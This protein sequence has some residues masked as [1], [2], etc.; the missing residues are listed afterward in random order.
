MWRWVLGILAML[1]LVV[2]LGFTGFVWVA[3]AGGLQENVMNFLPVLKR[4]LIF[5]DRNLQFSYEDYGVERRGFSPSVALIQPRLE[6]TEGDTRYLLNAPE[7]SI[8]GSFT[9]LQQVQ[10]ELPRRM[11]LTIK[12]AGAEPRNLMLEAQDDFTLTLT[13]LPETTMWHAYT[14]P[15]A[16]EL[17]LTVADGQGKRLGEKRYHYLPVAPTPYQAPYSPALLKQLQSF[18]TMAMAAP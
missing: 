6:V 9:Q 4:E 12:K 15:Q 2:V 13:T 17:V 18:E 1:V 14:L 16:G 11:Q 8:I 10:V 5:D 7:L 3:M